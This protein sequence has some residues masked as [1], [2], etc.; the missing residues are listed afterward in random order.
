VRREDTR[1]AVRRRNGTAS[2]FIDSG[3]PAH[4]DTAILVAQIG[5]IGTDMP[6]LAERTVD[7]VH[8]LYGAGQAAAAQGAFAERGIL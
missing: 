2:A 7:A 6:D 3:L 8:D 1:A 5:W 4:A